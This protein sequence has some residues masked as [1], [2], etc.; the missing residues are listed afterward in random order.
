MQKRK[1]FTQIDFIVIAAVA[2]L[3]VLILIP[4]LLKIRGRAQRMGC[5]SRLK[6]WGVTVGLYVAEHN[7]KMWPDLYEN[8]ETEARG[9]WVD[10]LRPYYEDLNYI[11]TCPGATKPCQDPSREKRGSF[12]SVWGVSGE[13]IP[14]RGFSHWGSYGINRWVSNAEDENWCYWRSTTV[15][16]STLVPVFLDSTLCN[17]MPS[18]TDPIPLTGKGDYSAVPIGAPGCQIWRFCIDRHGGAVN[19]WFLDGSA[20]RVRL[21]ELWDLKWHRQFEPQDYTK[22]DFI[23]QNGRRWLR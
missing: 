21:P 6:Q 12:D 10:V 20:R 3:L 14:G 19:I 22:D 23:D 17:A 5:I 8:D 9:P 13:I 4:A 1:R 18:D 15:K 16:D 11:R 7:S 2:M